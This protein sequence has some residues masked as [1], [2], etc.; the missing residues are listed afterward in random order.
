MRAP[1]SNSRRFAGQSP[2]ALP[3]LRPLGAL[4]RSVS[5]LRAHLC[6]HLFGAV[7]RTVLCF[8]TYI[9]YV[10]FHACALWRIL[11]VGAALSRLFYVESYFCDYDFVLQWLL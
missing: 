8:R 5:R 3:R 2:A 4:L 6:L 9:S 1:P 7:L 10:H 11:L